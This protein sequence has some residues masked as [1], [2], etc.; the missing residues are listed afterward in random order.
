MGQH[1]EDFHNALFCGLVLKLVQ[2]DEL[3]ARSR[4][5]EQ[6]RWLWLAIDSVTKVIPSL[7]LGRGRKNEDAYAVAHDLKERPDPKCVPSFMA[8]GLWG[9]FYALTAHFGYWFRPKR[10]RANHW[11]VEMTC[12]MGN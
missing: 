9:C 6:A 8:D 12:G 4:D 3:Y 5:S 7:H 11:A 2:L 10:A 1:S